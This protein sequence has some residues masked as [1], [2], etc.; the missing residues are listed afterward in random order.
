MNLKH[1]FTI[2]LLFLIAACSSNTPGPEVDRDIIPVSLPAPQP[3]TFTVD[4]VYP[5]DNK[6]F[7]Q[8]LEFYNGKLYEGTGEPNQSSLRIV[9]IKSGIPE[10]K[11]LIKDPAI[12]G[13]GVTIFN[14]KIYQLTWE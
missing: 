3:I 13:E 2:V 8:G 1:L 6:A 5:H 4:A 14:K 12:F 11:F 7:I 9:D 10:K